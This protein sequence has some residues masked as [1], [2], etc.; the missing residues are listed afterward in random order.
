MHLNIVLY[1]IV[2]FILIQSS[3]SQPGPIAS[4]SKYYEGTST[5]ESDATESSVIR[6]NYQRRKSEFRKR[7]VDSY[8]HFEV[9]T[10]RQRDEF[11]KYRDLPSQPNRL[12]IEFENSRLKFL[13]DVLKDKDLVTAL[14]NFS[15]NFILESIENWLKI[16]DPKA[17]IKKYS[18]GK[19]L[20]LII[21]KTGNI[22]PKDIAAINNIFD[23]F[24]EKIISSIEEKSVFR[25]SDN[26][27]E[28]FRMGVGQT[29]EEAYFA[30]RVLRKH[31]GPNR[32]VHF[33]DPMISGKLRETL[34]KAELDRSE[35]EKLSNLDFLLEIEPE[36]GKKIPN[37]KLF[38]ILRKSES[39]DDVMTGIYERFQ[40]S[41]GLDEATL[42]LTYAQRI[43]LLNPKFFVV[44]QTV[45]TLAEAKNGGVVI[46][47]KGMGSANQRA[48]AI[49]A[50]KSQSPASFMIYNR[51]E[52]AKV[53]KEISLY[54]KRMEEEWGARCRGDD[55]VIDDL[56][57]LDISAFLNSDLIR[58]QRV[59]FIPSDI[60]QPQWR[61]EMSTHGEAIEKLLMKTLYRYLRPPVL[62]T[63][64]IAINFKTKELGHGTVDLIVNPLINGP[65]HP[66]LKQTLLLSL[67]LSLI[68]FNREQKK[69]NKETHYISDEINR[70]DLS[71]SP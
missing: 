27:K 3:W 24:Q 21:E 43:D 68:D 44:D 19:S 16:S 66:E 4:C 70:K 38:E 31:E 39:A 22:N 47:R 42:L 26:I 25:R 11:I 63:F 34:S 5:R 61:S 64:T 6:S 67:K 58:G 40:T 54:R 53:T 18:D 37:I 2:S 12:V 56:D 32:A 65:V 20:T 9:T 52:E 15:N 28:W 71:P 48:S 1:L 36:T 45:V 46:D 23:S 50:A 62:D 59:V 60:A 8:L 49:A 7:L 33:S 30:V 14:D 17:S 55:C 41:I 35:I 51:L 29:P 13:N 69:Q 10:H 57:G